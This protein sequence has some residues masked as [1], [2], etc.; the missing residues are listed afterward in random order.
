MASVVHFNMIVEIN[1]LLRSKGIEYSIHAVGGCSCSGLHL[2]QDG[3]EYSREKIVEIINEYL[4]SKWMRVTIREDDE[5][6]LNIESKFD[7]IDRGE[8]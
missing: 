5:S 2:R 1:Q 3:E 6:L 4:D 8:K 7:F